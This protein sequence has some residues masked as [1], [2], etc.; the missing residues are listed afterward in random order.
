[1]ADLNSTSTL[2]NVVTKQVDVLFDVA[3]LLQAVGALNRE[4]H[5]AP[6][7]KVDPN[8]ITD[9]HTRLDV[10]LRLA[11]EKLHGALR[12]FNAAN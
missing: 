12:A 6:H 4:I 2:S 11:E 1:M 7:V 10:L 3:T 9:P 8:R 5:E